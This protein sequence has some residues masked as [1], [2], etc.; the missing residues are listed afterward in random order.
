MAQNPVKNVI[1]AFG[2]L[3]A[4]FTIWQ[5]IEGERAKK[6]SGTDHNAIL[7]ALKRIEQKLK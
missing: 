2:V 6:A 4:M 1:V 3:S 5:I 7:A